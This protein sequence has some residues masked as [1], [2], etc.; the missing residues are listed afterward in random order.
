MKNAPT[1]GLSKRAFARREG[2]HESTVREAIRNKRLAV[3]PDDTIDPALVGSPW[4]GRNMKRRP[5][6]GG[7][8]DAPQA[9]HG[10]L[11]EAIR[12]KETALATLREQE[13][14]EKA[15]K[16]VDA[17][18]V[19]TELFRIARQERDA[20]LNWPARAA[21]LMAAKLGVDQVALTVL[22]EEHVRDFL[23]DR[24]EIILQLPQ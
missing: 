20:L 15:G 8:G 2:C 7:A 21:P 23:A 6:A 24:S 12:R 5:G 11:D 10:T 22:M 1:V 19:R 14:A 3:L 16:L 17:A 13:V 18:A 9:G 4:K